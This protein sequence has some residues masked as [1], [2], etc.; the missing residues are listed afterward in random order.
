MKRFAF[1]IACVALMSVASVSAWADAAQITLSRSPN[2]SILFTDTGSGYTATFTNSCPGHANCI[3]GNAFLD[4][5]SSTF[6]GKYSMWMVG[7]PLNLTGG[8]GE[9]T[10][11]QGS[12]EIFLQVKLGHNGDGTQGV[13]LADV[14]LSDMSSGKSTATFEGS[15][16]PSTSTLNF[17]PQF[18]VGTWGTMSLTVDLATGSGLGPLKKGQTM[19]G[20]V[21]TGEIDAPVPEPASLALLGSGVL[22][23]AGVLRR[24]IW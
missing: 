17:L 22:G 20:R 7:G 21:S 11:N 12:T 14:E 23:L 5:G 2:N 24:K 19:Q 9:Y 16:L 4:L 10:V 18:P 1:V 3:A 15:F 13:F 6:T 8:S